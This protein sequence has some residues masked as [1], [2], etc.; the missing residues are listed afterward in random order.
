M[1]LRIEPKPA[2]IMAE[3]AIAC[4]AMSLVSD[5][6]APY[7]DAPPAAAGRRPLAAAIGGRLLGGAD[8]LIRASSLVPDEPVLDMRDFGWTAALRR[9]WR[10]IRE[11]AHGVAL[12]TGVPAT[13]ADRRAAR[14]VPI[15]RPDR[16]T[17]D[18]DAESDGSPRCP[19]T[20]AALAGVPALA[21]AVFSVLEPGT[22][23][24]A[25]RGAT[26][27]LVTCDLGLIVPRDGDVRMR[28]ADRVV[29]WAEG[30]TL[31]FDDSYEHEAWNAAGSACVILRVRFQRP[32]AQPARWIAD[33]LLRHM[34][35][36]ATD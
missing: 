27:G 28:V 4:P 34:R 29:R 9:D 16:R 25:R 23:L 13:S 12:A 17:G 22:H 36:G 7:H 32:L 24:P 35:G 1:P 21:G 31:V 30:E 20:I 26:K 5:V 8:R 2:S 6:A 15:G 14:E 18:G 10:A 11:E 3:K 19:R 33:R